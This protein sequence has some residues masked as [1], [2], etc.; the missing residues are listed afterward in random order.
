VFITDSILYL[1]V[2]TTFYQATAYHI[3]TS[4]SPVASPSVLIL[5]TRKICSGATGR[6][7]GHVKPDLYFNVSKYVST[8][9]TSAAAEVASFE[10]ANVSAVKDLVETEG[11]D[12]DFHLTRA[13][14]VYLDAEHAR[15]TTEAWKKLRRE[16]TV[17][18]RDVA[19]IPEKNAERVR[20][21]ALCRDI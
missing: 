17:D 1:Y 19:Y 13:I 21:L 11:L 3:L 2:L 8:Y 14:D 7:G 5:D 9:G 18:L 12:C 15:Q 6:N 4:S 20:M 16:K 10:A